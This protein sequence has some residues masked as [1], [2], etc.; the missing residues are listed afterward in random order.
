MA[1]GA[2]SEWHLEAGW[3]STSE[4]VKSLCPVFRY[5]LGDQSFQH[6]HEQ[7]LEISE[8]LETFVRIVCFRH[9]ACWVASV[10]PFH[11]KEGGFKISLLVGDGH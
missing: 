5:L 9:V 3:E 7:N 4:A 11:I 8:T 10:W 2:V 1:C 6:T